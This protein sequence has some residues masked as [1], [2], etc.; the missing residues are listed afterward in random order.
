MLASKG[1]QGV[2]GET[3]AQGEQ[4]IQGETG[5]D[6]VT[7]IWKGSMA[8][9]PENPSIYWAYFN[10]TDGSSYIYNGTGWDMLAS[11]GE[12]GIKGDTGAQGEQGLQGATG[13]AGVDGTMIIWKGSYATSPENPDLYWAY[14]N[15]DTGC[16]YIYNGTHWDLLAQK[17]D[18]GEQGQ[19]GNDGNSIEWKGSS[20]T[21]PSNPELY[22]AY[23]NTVTRCSYIYNGSQWDLLASNA[24][25]STGGNT[26]KLI[27]GNV[28]LAGT[29]D[30]SG[31]II[32]AI[33]VTNSAKSY[34]AMPNSSGAFSLSG[35]EAG[36][37]LINI[38]ARGYKAVTV[39]SVDMTT[40]DSV[41]LGSIS[42]ES[43]FG[44]LTGQ[45]LLEGFTD[46]SGVKV[47]LNGLSYEA[48]TDASGI[49]TMR[50]PVDTYTC[51]V[52]FERADFS[53]Q[54]FGNTVIINNDQT[55]VMNTINLAACSV[56][57]VYGVFDLEGFS[58]D[59]GIS[60][61]LANSQ[62]EYTSTT[63][64]DGA[65]S[66]DHVAV[67]TYELT[68]NKENMPSFYST[69]KIE[70]TPDMNIGT[71]KLTP[72][73]SSITGYVKLDGMSDHSGIEVRATRSDAQMSVNVVTGIDGSYYLSNI[74][75]DYNYTITY[76]KDGW[77]TQSFNQT[78]FSP[79]EV[80]DMGEITLVDT[81]APVLTE[82]TINNG[83]NTSDN[84][85]VTFAF[86]AEDNASGIS[87]I[88]V[89]YDNF[90]TISS[91]VDYSDTVTFALPAENRQH[92]VYVKLRD[93]S[94]N[95][96]GILS[97][98][99]TLTDQKYELRGA[100]KGDALH[101]TKA[102]S[103]Y[104]VTAN[105]NVEPEDTLIIDPGV[106]ILFSGEYGISVE[107]KIL[108]IGT[109]TEM[110]HMYG[111]DEGVNKWKGI[112]VENSNLSFSGDENNLTYIEG[113]KFQHVQID[114]CYTGFS[115]YMW[116]EDC[117]VNGYQIYR[118]YSQLDYERAISIDGCKFVIKDSVI[119]G[120]TYCYSEQESYV[121]NSRFIGTTTI[122][123][124]NS[125]SGIII[126]NTEFIGSVDDSDDNYGNTILSLGGHGSD[127]SYTSSYG[128]TIQRFD[129]VYLNNQY[130]ETKA[131]Y[132]G[133]VF[134]DINKLY[135]SNGC[136]NNNSVSVN[137]CRFENIR[138]FYANNGQY[139][140]YL[141]CSFDN[142]ELLKANQATNAT[143][144]CC[145]FNGVKTIEISSGG[146]VFN[147]SNLNDIDSL[148][149]NSARNNVKTFEVRNA[150]W[151][152]DHTTEIETV[153]ARGN[154]SFI[155]DYFDDITKTEIVYSNYVSNPY[156]ECG[157]SDKGY[158]EDFSITQNVDEY[159]CASINPNYEVTNTS[160][161]LLHVTCDDHVLTDYIM[162][163]SLS[164]FTG[165]VTWTS[166]S[167][168]GVI[169]AEYS[170]GIWYMQVRDENGAASSIKTFEMGCKEVGPAGGLV[171]Y[172]CDADNASGNADGLES[173]TCGW[174]FIEVSPE[175]LVVDSTKTFKF[176]YYRTEDNGENLFTNGTTSFSDSNCTKSAIG[177]G[178]AN[179]E[180]LVSKIGESAYS[181]S[182]G[183]SK[184]SNYAAK[185]AN[186]YVFGGY[187]DWFLPSTSELSQIVT[188]GFVKNLNMV[189]YVYWSSSEYTSNSLYSYDYRFYE[190]NCYRDYDSRSNDY[191]IRCMRYF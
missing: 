147:C 120:N 122:Q 170:Y 111:V 55:T 11:K 176:G 77:N 117:V 127:K 152:A 190:N 61:R 179:T 138:N 96:S 47:S 8:T 62:N 20:S 182:S 149:I 35:I 92:T 88:L 168:D 80:R 48:I 27:Y 59:S 107:G 126:T 5:A 26:N 102:N 93:G 160:N 115:G 133:C 97:G 109:E 184:T 153:G 38:A 4:G 23:Y 82:F 180:L 45:V 49:F 181:S 129:T 103:P 121:I 169:S 188:K 166:L 73:A 125:Q 173:A 139:I 123:S 110:I 167:A 164:D 50:I 128:C 37:Y 74:S 60:V 29:A 135:S 7:I 171:F 177:A 163:Q 113:S 3:G 51:G 24:S 144:D 183:S 98:T 76:S 156:A 165:T 57:R 10:S 1:E 31:A 63:L 83:A 64:A 94:G 105:C 189:G 72:N 154:L 100:L 162:S 106:D 84:N 114:N 52:L 13:P 25:D 2:Q 44:T 18:T 90:A 178:K 159:A 28:S 75:S 142:V 130:Y 172:D 79:L 32:T 56:S 104:I 140:S 9:A 185:L 33:D 58:D 39:S 191:R 150:Y 112:K 68:A 14:Y 78:D 89:S 53:S 95:I 136:W 146:L 124:G 21:A 87:K 17:G 30:S 66:F 137:N 151:G 34:S 54:L 131:N 42:L 158:I 186:D 15:T 161:G 101:L 36:T 46:Y 86:T 155:S 12:Q 19:G 22:W 132:Y 85:N 175:D 40:N 70:S 187:E 6:G 143:Y 43:A 119:T 16:S 116:I 91:Y 65:W 145:E 118:S 99:I 134:K 69:V 148:I 41:D 108:A 81:T 71:I 67:G 141:G 174:R 157:Y